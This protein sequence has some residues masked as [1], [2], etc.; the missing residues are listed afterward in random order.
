MAEGIMIC[1][2][3]VGLLQREWKW[4]NLRWWQVI[5]N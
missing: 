3:G 5:R 2:E 1:S 4:Y